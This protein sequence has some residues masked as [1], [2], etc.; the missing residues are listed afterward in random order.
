MVNGIFSFGAGALQPYIGAGVGVARHDGTF[1]EQTLEAGGYAVRLAKT[2]DEDTVLA[3]QG[4]V[5]I[6]YP[7]SETTEA[8]LGYRYFA[9]ADADFDGLKASYGTHNFEAGITFRF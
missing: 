4:M 5:G 8:R 6:S 2:S 1:D 9:T 3:Y 7:L